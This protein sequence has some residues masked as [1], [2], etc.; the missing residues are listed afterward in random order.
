[1]SEYGSSSDSDTKADVSRKTE[2]SKVSIKIPPFS[3]N[4]PKI[5]FW[6]IE[7]Q[8]INCGIKA[9]TTKYHYVVGA[10]DADVAE[11]I[12]DIMEK[13][14]S[15]TPYSDLKKRILEEF[16]LTQA[17]KAKK[18]LTELQLGDKKPSHLLRE[19]RSLAGKNVTDEFL[20]SLFLDRLP[21]AAKSIL[22]ASQSEKL[23]DLAA[24]ADRILE[25]TSAHAIYST[26]TTPPVDSNI[27]NRLS[28][29]E[30]LVSDISNQLSQLDLRGRS[31]S[32][33][34]SPYS[35][36]SRSRSNSQCWYHYT[37]GDEA[38]KC[39]QPCNFKTKTAPSG[40]SHLSH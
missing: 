28:Q 10:L 9:E 30:S 36:R 15:A 13:E 29:L 27:S 25:V 32:R 40:N 39:V 11:Q 14:L 17:S 5:W 3:R 26:S 24:M 7:S 38:K 18:L 37:F 35:R 6:Q 8:F 34:S 19:M 22:A 23:D 16:E 21:H 31:R 1:M 33:N 2:I 4:K 12:S 20:R